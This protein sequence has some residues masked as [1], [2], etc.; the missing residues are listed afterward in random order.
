V[1]RRKLGRNA[2]ASYIETE[3]GALPSHKFIDHS[4]QGSDFQG[5][6]DKSGAKDLSYMIKAY[7]DD[8]IY[9]A[10]PRTKKNLAHVANAVMTGIHDVI[11][12]DA[13]DAK[14]PISLKKLN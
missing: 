2:V 3:V 7:V 4:A 14:D 12:A 10:I 8:Y 5:F 11:P 6:D 13:K 9:L 1:W